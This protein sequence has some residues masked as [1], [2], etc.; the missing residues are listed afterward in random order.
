MTRMITG[1][2]KY[3]PNPMPNFLQRGT[4][5]RDKMKTERMSDYHESKFNIFD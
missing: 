4:K 3:N 5:N 2:T 1:S